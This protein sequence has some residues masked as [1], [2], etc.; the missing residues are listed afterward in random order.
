MTASR[1]NYA[2]VKPQVSDAEATQMWHEVDRRLRAQPRRLRPQVWLLA[3]SVLL[4]AFTSLAALVWLRPSGPQAVAGTMLEAPRDSQ[5][6]LGLPDGSRV[7]LEPGAQA[8]VAR[9]EGKEVVVELTRGGAWFDV[10]HVVGRS[11]IV[12]ATD[13]EVHVVGTR[14]RVAYSGSERDKEVSVEVTRG[15]VEVRRPGGRAPL[16]LESGERWASG[17]RGAPTAVGPGAPAELLAP[18]QNPPVALPPSRANVGGDPK[19]V[20]VPAGQGPAADA[21]AAL[22]DA[23]NHARVAGRP[24]EAARAFDKFRRTYRSDSRAA[25]AAFQLGR[26]RIDELGSP[27]A[28][29]EAFGDALALGGNAS[30]RDDALARLVEAHERAG[31]LAACRK[32]Q[33]AYLAGESAGAHRAVV[34]RR[35]G[36]VGSLKP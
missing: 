21:S 12:R 28:A 14:F 20:P 7:E 23:A 1:S 6:T 13:V 19:P 10:T 25:L 18:S 33:L 5:Q 27:A 15:V 9:L 16:A 11:F 17:T 32:A 26:L 31:N 8:R 36:G 34:E 30:L 35:C 3:A 29:A 22:F 4:L 24:E 2:R